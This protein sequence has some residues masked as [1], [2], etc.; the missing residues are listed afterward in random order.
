MYRILTEFEV[1]MYW[2]DQPHVNLDT[3]PLSGEALP[4][5]RAGLF[6]T[7]VHEHRKTRLLSDLQTEESKLVVKSLNLMQCSNQSSW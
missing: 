4:F 6:R 7:S 3:E 2:K 5:V 1:F